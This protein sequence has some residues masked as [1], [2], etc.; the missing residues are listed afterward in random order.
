VSSVAEKGGS[1][2][3]Q[4]PARNID[5][6]NVDMTTKTGLA[7][8]FPENKTEVLLVD[9]N[10]IQAATRKAILQRTGKEVAI[11]ENAMQ[12][13]KML[14]DESF[15]RGLG[16]VVT[17][18]LMPGMNGPV[19][20]QRLRQVLPEVPVLVL[21][22]LPDAEAEYKGLDIIFRLKPLAPEALIHLATGLMNPRVGRTA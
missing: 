22:G 5:G 2:S 13:L 6:G 20:V 19:L 1:G 10:A 9:D 4:L 17:D 18:H 14:E 21:S 3:N 8:Q 12:A 15:A 7:L 11:A 16:L